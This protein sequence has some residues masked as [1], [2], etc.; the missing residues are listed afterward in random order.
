MIKKIPRVCRRTFCAVTLLV[1]LFLTTPPT[2]YKAQV[3]FTSSSAFDAKAFAALPVEK[4]YTFVKLLSDGAWQVR[5]D[6]E[7]KPTRNEVV[8]PCPWLGPGSQIRS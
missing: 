7:A 2:S 3:P 8:V 6:P 5:R 4:S 1:S